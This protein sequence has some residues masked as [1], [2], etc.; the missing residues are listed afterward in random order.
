MTTYCMETWCPGRIIFFPNNNV[1][2]V[3]SIHVYLLWLLCHG[4]LL[5]DMKARFVLTVWYIDQ[6]V[7]DLIRWAVT[8]LKSSTGLCILCRQQISKK[9]KETKKPHNDHYRCQSP[10]TVEEDHSPAD[11]VQSLKC[12]CFESLRFGPIPRSCKETK[13]QNSWICHIFLR[14]C[15]NEAKDCGSRSPL[16]LFL[17]FL[18]I[19]KK[20]W[21]IEPVNTVLLDFYSCIVES[22]LTSSMT[23]TALESTGELPQS[24]KIP[25]TPSTV[26]SHFY[27]QARGTEVLNPRPPD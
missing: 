4:H 9:K 12:V 18:L 15:E 17:K 14:Y 10:S 8:C 26:C 5:N 20:I 1:S 19:K 23:G 13:Q 27:P 21:G 22:I 7:D 25:P 11:P 16:I 24:S 3:N 2:F 6:T